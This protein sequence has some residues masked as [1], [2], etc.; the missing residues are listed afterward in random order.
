MEIIVGIFVSLYTFFQEN[1]MFAALYMGV[2]TTILLII[3]GIQW[4]RFRKEKI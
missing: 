1:T 3:L 2:L 4:L